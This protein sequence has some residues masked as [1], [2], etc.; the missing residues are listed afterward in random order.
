M[1]HLSTSPAL[2]RDQALRIRAV[3]SAERAR[4]E[5]AMAM[6]FSADPAARWAWPDPLQFL[7]VF[8]PLVTLFGG[9]SFDHGSAFVVGDYLGVAQWLPPGVLPD[10]G[11]IGALFEQHMSGPKL[12]EL[13]F[14]F[15]Q[16][17]GFHPREPHW[18]IPLIG[19]DPALQGRGYGSRLMRHG[20][21]ACD[22]DRQLVYLEATSLNNRQFYERHGF[23]VLGEIR[24]GD[25][26]PMF[27]M[28]REPRL[29]APAQVSGLLDDFEGRSTI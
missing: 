19:V 25:S 18:Y 7:T 2:H 21:A 26:P 28:Q 5:A 15:E 9:K 4:F 10:D 13:L 8:L 6:A 12:G 17:A 22:R 3:P 20:L 27:P 23:R 24:S 1:N 14:L 29:R 11:P 16:M